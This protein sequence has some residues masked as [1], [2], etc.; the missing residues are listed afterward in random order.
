MASTEATRDIFS[1]LHDGTI[2]AWTGD[3]DLLTL[4]ID[5][6]YL[7]RRIN[8]SFDNFY[9]D[10]YKV[11]KIELD[12]WANPPG[13]PAIIKTDIADIFR[14]ELELLSADIKEGTVVIS[15]NQHDTDFDYC[16]GNL[17][18]SC[19]KIKV[20]DQGRNELTIDELW[21]ICK[22]YWDDWS[23]R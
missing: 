8:Q 15:C 10:L 1:I 19:H 18:I 23:R 2:V 21:T 6:Q 3:R 20:F 7:A 22:N 11:D 16:G 17:T 14:A 4:T 13:F 5:C 9:V 12:P